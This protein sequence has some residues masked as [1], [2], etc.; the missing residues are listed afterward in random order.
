MIRAGSVE[1]GRLSLP[2]IERR[3]DTDEGNEFIS[4]LGM[5][6]TQKC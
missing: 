1:C 3:A 2:L 4:G 5:H 6:V